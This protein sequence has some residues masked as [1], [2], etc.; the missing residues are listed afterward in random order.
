MAVVCFSDRLIAGDEETCDRDCVA[1]A[2]VV[3]LSFAVGRLLHLVR[4]TMTAATK[5]EG[6]Q[7]YSRRWK[8]ED[9]LLCTK[10]P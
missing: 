10:G 6:S 9:R 7:D 4:Q 8:T 1:E 5:T 2:R 3:G